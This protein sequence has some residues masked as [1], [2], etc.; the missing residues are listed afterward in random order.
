MSKKT[1]CQAGW[2]SIAFTFITSITTAQFSFE[3]VSNYQKSKKGIQT[4]VNYGSS[5]FKVGIGVDYSF[6]NYERVA[7][8]SQSKFAR[9]GEEIPNIP[10]FVINPNQDLFYGS[11]RNAQYQYQSYGSFINSNL[12]IYDFKYNQIPLQVFIG[13]QLGAN[14]ISENYIINYKSD[15][16]KTENA[17]IGNRKFSSLFFTSSFGLNWNLT[18]NFSITTKGN[19][20]FHKPLLN[21]DYEVDLYSPYAGNSYSISVGIKYDFYRKGSPYSCI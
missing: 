18:Q 3:A 7:D 1:T 2:I 11:A 8:F 10:I 17:N 16:R 9:N 20:S 6:G 4:N 19:V 21:T 12:R 13:N 5:K 14:I 15:S